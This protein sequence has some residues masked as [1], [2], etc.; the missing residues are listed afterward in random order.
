MI[1]FAFSPDSGAAYIGMVSVLLMGLISAYAEFRRV[2]REQRIKDHE[3]ARDDYVA[4]LEECQRK[5]KQTDAELTECRSRLV[6]CEAK[7]LKLSA[8]VIELVALL[9]KKK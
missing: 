1:A 2:S 7:S 9:A 5:V 3:A 6:D 4:S 8:Q